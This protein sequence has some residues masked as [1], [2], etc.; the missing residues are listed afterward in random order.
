[1]IKRVNFCFAVLLVSFG[2]SC[3]SE[4]KESSDTADQKVVHTADSFVDAMKNEKFSEAYE[5]LHPKLK[6]NWKQRP[7]TL[8]DFSD[9]TVA[10][11]FTLPDDFISN[12]LS[13]DKQDEWPK[14]LF[15]EIMKLVFEQNAFPIEIAA[16]SSINGSLELPASGGSERVYT[17]SDGDKIEVKLFIS[18]VSESWKIL[19][20]EQLSNGV[21][22]SWP[23]GEDK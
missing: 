22:V 9:F 2:V 5:Y 7:V 12:T 6:K 14:Y 16:L 15:A 3:T 23:K 1:M 8:L 4:L 20:I 18:E 17:I 11:R 10:T 19:R 21:F 13:E